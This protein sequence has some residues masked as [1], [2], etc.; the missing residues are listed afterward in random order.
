MKFVLAVF[1]LSAIFSMGARAANPEITILS[2]MVANFSGEGEWG[3]SALIETGE[4]T[5]LFDTGFKENTVLNNAS[6]LKKDLS[7]V[8]KVILSHFHTDHTGGLLKL[9]ETF[10]D[11]N[12][13]AFSKVYVGRGF[14]EQ[15]YT[16]GGG[17]VYSLPGQSFSP[18]FTSAAEF[19]STAEE[20][21]ITFIVIDAPTDIAEGM[22]LT[23]PI[24][25]VHDERNVS[26]GFFL[27]ENDEL[28]A[29][30]VPE[31]Q[32]LGIKTDKGWILV[33]GCGHAGI[34]NAAE[35][36]KQIDD[37]PIHMGVGGL[38]LFRASV[39]T[40]SWTAGKLKEFGVKKIIGAHCT[41]VHATHQIARALELARSDV[42]V[43][44]IG[45]RIDKTLAIHPA[46]I[47]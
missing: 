7:A 15:R 5:I 37:Q 41:G 13:Q 46:S 8:E 45:T 18:F 29:D 23:G 17:P 42:S 25:R 19:R 27:K 3:F 10:R 33:S 24:E 1:V 12:P 16:S 22:T 14:F 30:T 6:S 9:R 26:P 28:V 36:L 2:T 44:A 11:E 47:E 31:S 38:H 39:E 34:I 43:G 4:E 32:S 21:G 20:L 35:K 40:V